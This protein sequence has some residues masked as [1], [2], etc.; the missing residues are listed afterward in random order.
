MMKLNS[1]YFFPGFSRGLQ[2]CREYPGEGERVNPG[3]RENRLENSPTVGESGGE[4]VGECR[5]FGSDSMI[6]RSK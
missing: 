5:L 3:E 2:C 1:S 6:K 4:S